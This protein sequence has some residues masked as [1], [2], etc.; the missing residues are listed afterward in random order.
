MIDIEGIKTV[1][2]IGCG[3]M[4]AGI[5]ACCLRAGYRVIGFE[6]TDELLQKGLSSIRKIAMTSAGTEDSPIPAMESALLDTLLTGSTSY[7]SF[8]DCDV[9]IEAAP[10]K[11]E[12][13]K[14]I[15]VDLET[16]VRRNT[17]IC[18]NTSSLPIIDISAALQH[19]D[20][21]VG[22]HFCYPAEVIPLVELIPSIQTSE[23]MAELAYAF[24]KTLGK[25]LIRAKDYPGF[26]INYLQYPFRLNAIRM[27][28][29]GM[30]TPEDIDAAARLGLGHPY[31]PLEFQDIVGLDVTYNA[32]ESIYNVTHDPL[33]NPPVLMAQMVSANM[34]GRK[35][36]KGFYTYDKT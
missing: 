7:T 14:S 27:V 2:V 29:R 21:F 30:A 6:I 26:I 11:L 28:E 34:L 25:T 10:E 16:V 31:G 19:P 3:T 33:F 17:L 5:A 32:C 24:G 1:G 20:R 9:I 18:T 13:K 8:S 35:T 4:G 36:G 22:L 23:D 12:L 15:M